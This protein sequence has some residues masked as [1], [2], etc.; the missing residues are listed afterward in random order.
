MGNVLLGVCGGIAAYKAPELARLLAKAGHVVDVVLTESAAKLVSP[1]ALAAVTRRPVR[2]SMWEGTADGRMDHIDLAANADA[3]VIAPATADLLARAAAGRAADLLSACLLVTRAPVLLAPA[4][5]S[6]M[7]EH[8]F[9][10]RN[11]DALSSLPNVRW[12]GPENGD[13]ACGWTGPGRMADPATIVA[14]LARL[15]RRDLEG[16]SLLVTAGP[17]HEPLDAHVGDRVEHR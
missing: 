2:S 14:A 6:R 13:L 4:M 9:T 12:V 8:P 15:G 17:T 5:N 11:A 1:T 16:R 10:R 3:V 7:W